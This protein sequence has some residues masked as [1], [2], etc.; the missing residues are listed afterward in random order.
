MFLQNVIAISL[1]YIQ[2]LTLVP[3][4]IASVSV[5]TKKPDSETS[6]NINQISPT[7]TP[8]PK[9]ESDKNDDDSDDLGFEIATFQIPEQKNKIS[10]TQENSSDKIT[11]DEPKDSK[12]IEQKIEPET[13][14]NEKQKPETIDEETDSELDTKAT[15]PEEKIQSRNIPSDFVVDFEGLPKSLTESVNPES[16]EEEFALDTDG[17][18]VPG[19][20]LF[21]QLLAENEARI[22]EEEERLSKSVQPNPAEPTDQNPAS[23]SYIKK[24]TIVTTTTTSYG[25]KGGRTVAVMPVT[26]MPSVNAT[27]IATD[28]AYRL[29]RLAAMGDGVPLN[30]VWAQF[31]VEAGRTHGVDPVLILEVC[32]QE[33]RFKNGARSYANAN[34][35][36]QFIPATAA[37]FG[38][39]P[40]DPRQAIF[41]GAK[42]L[43]FLLNTFRG[44][45]R[46]AL[47]GYNA[48]EGA[49]IAFATGRTLYPKNGKVINPRGIRTPLGIP[50][51]EE[52]Q[53]YV[54]VIYSKYLMSLSR[55]K[56]L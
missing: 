25:K 6:A 3:A 41:G 9:K 20:K 38:I 40:Y 33:S 8:T 4:G 28:D 16:D 29:V 15:K 23:A 31:M 14:E 18:L 44:E 34:G 30:P 54:S 32:R 22:K 55:L 5:N 19:A 13:I 10:E 12:K 1:L 35:L 43:R 7:P 53:N 11:S 49:V 37:R 39:D 46:S 26:S 50:P 2:T 56:T 27:Y 52:T 21:S 48:G 24:T 47:A 17:D 51:Y 45:V 42:Y 36:M